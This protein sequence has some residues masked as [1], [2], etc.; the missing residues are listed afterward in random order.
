LPDQRTVCT[1]SVLYVVRANHHL[2]TVSNTLFHA[3]PKCHSNRRWFWF[4]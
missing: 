3:V 4:S 1:V 2:D